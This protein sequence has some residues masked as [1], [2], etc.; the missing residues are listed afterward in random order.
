MTT[1]RKSVD[2]IMV[3][4]EEQQA[5]LKRYLGKKKVLRPTMFM[6]IAQ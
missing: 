6:K 3:K 2:D 4:V 5:W 1:V